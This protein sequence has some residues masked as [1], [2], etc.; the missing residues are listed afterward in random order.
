MKYGLVAVDSGLHGQ[1]LLVEVLSLLSTNCIP[2]N[3]IAHSL[4]CEN[5]TRARNEEG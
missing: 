4:H 2:H 5:S 1:K 3:R